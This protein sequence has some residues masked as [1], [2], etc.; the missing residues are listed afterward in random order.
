MLMVTTTMRMLHGVHS[1]TTNLRPAV[2]LDAELVVCITG[3]EHGLLGSSTACNLTDHSTA[4]TWH[5]FLCPRWKL[6]STWYHY[7]DYD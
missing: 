5:N 4:S 2:S 6:H 3:L 1:N 7:P